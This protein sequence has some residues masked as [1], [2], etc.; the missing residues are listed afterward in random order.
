MVDVLNW[1]NENFF[2]VDEI[3]RNAVREKITGIVNGWLIINIKG[4]EWM[5]EWLLR[6]WLITR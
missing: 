3:F 2:K 1:R 6:G 5:D 4:D